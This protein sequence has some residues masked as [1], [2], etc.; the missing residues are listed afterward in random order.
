MRIF[1]IFYRSQAVFGAQN[2]S[3]STVDWSSLTRKH[4][5]P[6]Y[7]PDRIDTTTFEYHG[8]E[9]NRSVVEK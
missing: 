5:T 6:A 9:F 2:G 3:F 1:A 7:S 8:H 4:A